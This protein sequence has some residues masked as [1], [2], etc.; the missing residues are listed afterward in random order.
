MSTPRVRIAPSP[1]GN[2]HVGTARA[3]LFNYLFAENQSGTFILRIEDTDLE[4]S[5]KKYE[6]NIFDGL[7][8]LGINPDEG[9]EQGG[10]HAPYR[11][12]ERT[13]VYEKH[14]RQLLAESKAFYC[15]HS[16]KEL[17]AEKERM[18]A[19]KLPVLHGCAYRD[20]PPAEAEARVADIS[21]FIIRFKTPQGRSIVFPDLIRGDVAF[22]SDLIGDFSIAKRPDVPLYNFAVVVDDHAMNITHVIRGEDHIA[23][24]PKQI[25]IAEALGFPAVAYAHLPLILGADRS[26]LS[27]RHGAMSV[28]EYRQQGYLPEALFNFMALLGWNPGGDQEIFSKEELIRSFSLEKVQKSGAIFDLK[29]LDWMNGEYIR[30]LSVEELLVHAK[31]FLPKSHTLYPASYVLKVL[32]LEQPRLKKLSELAER[33]DYFFGASAYE[34]DLLRWKSISDEDI[35]VSLEYCEQILRSLGKGASKDTIE[36]TFM[37]A[38]GEGD[39]GPILWPL[40]VAL[41]GKK[42]SPGP[43]EIMAILG[44]DESIGRVQA[45]LQKVR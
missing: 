34:K 3:A 7:R 23:N 26:K 27:K 30:A 2:L 41:S 13:A 5:D 22:S 6:Q 19:E 35:A 9:P 42:A 8:W 36:N 20:M 43:F 24:T 21:D 14:I 15:F 25:L 18:M 40:R 37:E 1:T 4:R 29:K 32:A 38:I 31:D 39:K 33:V 11:Q 44:V 17:T 45:A 10:P 28:D 16:E 12:T